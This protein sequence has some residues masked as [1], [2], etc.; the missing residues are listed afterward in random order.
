MAPTVPDGRDVQ[1]PVKHEFSETFERDKF[2]GKFFV[3]GD[4]HYTCQLF[5]KT[6][7]SQCLLIYSL[8]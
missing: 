8:L 4:L 6:S 5:V 1:V 2:D 3:K 7:V